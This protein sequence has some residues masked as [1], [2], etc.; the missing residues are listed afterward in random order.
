MG[1]SF[2]LVPAIVSVAFVLLAMVIL[3]YD[4]REMTFGDIILGL[5]ACFIPGVNMLTAIISV[6][7]VIGLIWLGVVGIPAVDRF[8]NKSPFK[9]N[10]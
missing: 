6:L 5:L 4:F 8:L 3:R 7:V 2:Y 10:L 1:F 9:K